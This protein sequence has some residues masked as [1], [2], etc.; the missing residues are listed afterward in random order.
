MGKKL[1]FMLPDRGGGHLRGATCIKCVNNVKHN[2]R[3]ARRRPTDNR[4]L[5]SGVRLPRVGGESV[6]VWH[7]RK[8][9]LLVKMLISVIQF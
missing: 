5:I 3:K 6:L 2:L 8:V 1:H 4:P 7:R 9:G